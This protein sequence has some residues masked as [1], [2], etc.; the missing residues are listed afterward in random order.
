MSHPRRSSASQG[1]LSTSVAIP[2]PVRGH[3]STNPAIH[4][5]FDMS[6]FHAPV[7]TNRQTCKYCSRKGN[8]MRSNVVCRVCKVHLCL[9]AGRNCFLNEGGRVFTYALPCPPLTA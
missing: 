9:N 2:T 3:R 6:L 8:I 5:R 7:Y 4:V 1:S